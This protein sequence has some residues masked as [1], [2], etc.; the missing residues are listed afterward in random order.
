MEHQHGDGHSVCVS[1]LEEGRGWFSL[2][3][4]KAVTERLNYGGGLLGYFLLQCRCQ[5]EYLGGQCLYCA[6]PR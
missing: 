3:L 1:M 2:N 6:C 4:E 5:S